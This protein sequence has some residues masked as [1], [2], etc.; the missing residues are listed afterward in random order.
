LL[1]NSTA[2]A[3]LPEVTPPVAST[4]VAEIK[5]EARG[6][7]VIERVLDIN[8]CDFLVTVDGSG[9]GRNDATISAPA[10]R[11]EVLVHGIAPQPGPA[12]RS[13]ALGWFSL[14][15][16]RGSRIRLWLYGSPWLFRRWTNC[17]DDNRAI[18]SRDVWHARLR[19][20]L[21]LPNYTAQGGRLPLAI[22]S[23]SLEATQAP[24]LG[25]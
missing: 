24:T 17:A 23:L 6:A 8:G 4:V 22:G 5:A 12:L 2:V 21:V 16:C 10:W 14:W 25:C 1:S 9:V 13:D 11:G 3:T 7:D 20:A 18:Q 19:P 15:P